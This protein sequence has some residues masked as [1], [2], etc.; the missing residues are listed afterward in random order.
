MNRF[1]SLPSQGLPRGFLG[2]SWGAC[3]GLPILYYYKAP[4]RTQGSPKDPPPFPPGRGIV[5]FSVLG[6]YNFVVF[7]SDRPIHATEFSRQSRHIHFERSEI[8][9]NKQH[10]Q[11]SFKNPW[12]SDYSQQNW[13]FRQSNLNLNNIFSDTLW[14]VLENCERLEQG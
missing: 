5:V 12:T 4:I 6:M 10:R 8:I 11:P 13:V 2:A 14:R 1:S 3:L 9:C 7:L